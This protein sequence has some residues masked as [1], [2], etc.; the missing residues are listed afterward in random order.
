MPIDYHGKVFRSLSNSGSGEVDQE[1]RFYYQQEG[2]IVTATY[3][4]GA[5]QHGQLIALANP[6]GT[7]NMRYQHVNQ[8]GELMTGQCTSTPEVLAS[9]KLR[10]HEQWT[11]TSG[12][13]SSGTSIVEEI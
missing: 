13:H 5:I 7:L 6:E 1:T 11:W 2:Q 9:G 10:M 8:A 3:R 4:G 12:D